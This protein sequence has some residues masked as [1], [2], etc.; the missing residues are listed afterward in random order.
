MAIYRF[1]MLSFTY[2]FVGF[3]K[4]EEMEKVRY[5]DDPFDNDDFELRLN[6]VKKN[7]RR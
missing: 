6:T 3:S 1:R 2:N 7:M 4:K 5:S